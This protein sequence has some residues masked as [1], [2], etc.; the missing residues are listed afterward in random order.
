MSVLLLGVGLV[1]LVFPWVMSRLGRGVAPSAWARWCVHTVWLGTLSLEL[2]LVTT[3]LPTVL[4]AF[5]VPAL[6]RACAHALAPLQPGGSIGGWAAAGGSLWLFG[7]VLIGWRRA[8]SAQARGFV[9]PLIGHHARRY[10]VDVVVLP[11]SVPLAYSVKGRRAQVVLTDGL[12]H[13]L[14]PEELDA[15]LRHEL[16]H[17]RR[18]HQ[19]YLTIAVAVETA[20]GPLAR[21][22]TGEF[23]LAIERAADEDA[24]SC[25]PRRRKLL[26]TALL[27]SATQRRAAVATLSPATLVAERIH[28]LG[29]APTR[30]GLST[31]LLVH[32]PTAAASLT[33]VAVLSISTAHISHVIVMAGR[34]L[35]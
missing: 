15:V 35:Q 10:G 27:T 17:L 8:R 32:T 4:R 29:R 7:T 23:R 20:F 14:R 6:A 25:D 13:S 9:E 30:P 18:H 22:V 12:V 31:R 26:Q 3:S 34:C 11:S 21:I 16:A 19:S 5:G 28:A 24:T 2:G 33:A 1:L